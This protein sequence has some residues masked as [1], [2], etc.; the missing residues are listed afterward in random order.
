MKRFIVFTVAASI[1]YLV[2]SAIGAL[3]QE[4]RIQILDPARDGT[5]V[6]RTL[7]VKG[8]ASI[9]SGTHLWILTRREDFEGIW[10]PQGE[11]KVDPATGDWKVSATFGTQDDVGWNFDIAAVLVTDQSHIILRDYRTTAMRTGDWKPIELP[12]VEIPPVL[13]KVKKVGH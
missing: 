11:G 10:W 5:E 3:S 7:V 12:K 1:A 13:R 2:A 4:N 6:R 9:P 8:S